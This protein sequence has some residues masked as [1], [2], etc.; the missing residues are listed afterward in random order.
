[1]GTSISS[2]FA[3]YNKT[4]PDGWKFFIHDAEHTFGLRE[5]AGG[6]DRTRWLDF[7]TTYT[8]PSYFNPVWLHQQ[9][10]A[11]TEYKMAF[12]DGVYKHL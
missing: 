7:G 3:I 4:R 10:S 8:G 2:L 1:M 5:G 6:A 9:L 12:A 11:N